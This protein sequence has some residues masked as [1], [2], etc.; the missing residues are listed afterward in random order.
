MDIE[1]GMHIRTKEDGYIDKVVKTGIDSFDKRK[2]V[3]AKHTITISSDIVK[4]SHNIKD[5]LEVG[6]LIFIKSKLY[7]NSI[8]QPIFIIDEKTIE[9]IKQ[10]YNVEE[11]EIDSILT[12]EQISQNQYVVGGKVRC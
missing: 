11:Y 3:E 6:D 4:A 9:R 2:W 10:V 12:H 7:E 1:V 8:A 5:L